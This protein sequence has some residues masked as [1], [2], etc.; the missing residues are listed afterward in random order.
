MRESLGK[1]VRARREELGLSQQA[2]AD[3]SN[4]AASTIR[5]IEAD[6]V[7]E[8]RTW[9]QIEQ[10]LGWMPGSPE[11]IHEGQ[12]PQPILD[13][14]ALRIINGVIL[15]ALE[16]RYE[17]RD[18]IDRLTHQA[19]ASSADLA[20]LRAK[21]S[22]TPDDKKLVEAAARAEE[23]LSAARAGLSEVHARQAS[24]EAKGHTLLDLHRS[25][26][27]ALSH[28]ADISHG[29]FAKRTH[30]YLSLLA[31]STSPSE[32]LELMRGFKKVIS[33]RGWERFAS[34]DPTFQS[35]GQL[36]KTE[37]ES[38]IRAP[39]AHSV[40]ILDDAVQK[41]EKITGRVDQVMIPIMVDR[42]TLEGLDNADFVS[43]VNMLSEQAQ[44][45]VRVL[46][47]AKRRER[48]KQSHAF[49]SRSEWPSLDI[50]G[51]E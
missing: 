41:T 32:R 40:T 33:A 21:L 39:E 46:A 8:A 42:S 3:I 27:D 31:R 14:S 44:Q 11:A 37:S 9:S 4:V 48:N 5:N 15:K 10:A 29:G 35:I 47:D 43:V 26:M 7:G 34:V 1:A 2:L 50:K 45:F 23:Q 13:V 24:F 51:L 19:H 28:G 36:Q 22:E 16:R 38:E 18:A 30:H 49:E 20:A 6:R 12:T 17:L 25:T